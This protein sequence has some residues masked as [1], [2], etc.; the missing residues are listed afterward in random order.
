MAPVADD[1]DVANDL[2][3]EALDYQISEARR[4]VPLAIGGEFCGVC[5]EGI[6]PARRLLGYSICVPCA[7]AAER[8]RL[9][10]GTGYA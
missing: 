2:A 9:M 3:Q 1:V 6:P 4:A 5:D 7:A 10:V 8:R